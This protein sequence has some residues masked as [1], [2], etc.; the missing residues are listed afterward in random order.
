MHS[1]S[2]GRENL[3]EEAREKAAAEIHERARLYSESRIYRLDNKY[4]DERQRVDVE[5]WFVTPVELFYVGIGILLL[6]KQALLTSILISTIFSIALMEYFF[7]NP[8]SGLFYPYHRAV[9]K[10]VKGHVLTLSLLLCSVLIAGSPWWAVLIIASIYLLSAFSPS[11]VSSVI[12]HGNRMHPKYEFAKRRFN[13]QY[14]WDSM[15][16]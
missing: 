10:V 13:L 12:L 6:L 4:L 7:W 5:M 2:D 3:V 11:I 1:S 16:V 9:L 15:G 8:N 14:P